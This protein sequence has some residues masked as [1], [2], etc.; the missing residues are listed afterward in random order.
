MTGSIYIVQVY[1]YRMVVINA[2]DQSHLLIVCLPFNFLP[3][4]VS[5]TPGL[6]TLKFA[7]WHPNLQGGLSHIRL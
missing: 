6:S 3:L 1:M 7:L 4:P 5:L 2:H